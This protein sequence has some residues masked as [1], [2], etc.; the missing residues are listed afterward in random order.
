MPADCP[1]PSRR[2][3]EVAQIQT[4]AAKGKTTS[5]DGVELPYL[6]VANVQDGYVDLREIK[7]I[8]VEPQQV[9]RYSL[10]SGDVL[11]TEGGDAD[12]LGR[13]C[14]WQGQI[15]PCLHQNH[16]FAVRTDRTCLL[17]EFLSLY[18]A[19]ASG[20]S[21]FLE[22]AKQTTNL[23]SVNS[24]QL[25]DFPVAIPPL[26]EQRKIT[27]ILSSVDDAI[28]TTQAVIDQLG[29]VK[30]ALM[31]ELL[32]RGIPGRHTKFKQTEIG[33]VPAEW[34]VRTLGSLCSEPG[35]YGANVPKRAYDSLLPR[36]VRITDIT[37]DSELA[38]DNKASISEQDAAPFALRIGDIVFARSG[39]TVGKTYVYSPQ[40][41][42]CSHAGYLIRFHP[43]SSRML[44]SFLGQ[45]TH[46]ERYL[47]WVQESQR[48]QAQPNINAT[49]YSSL[50]LPVP[51]LAE[52]EHIVGALAKV[53]ERRKAESLVLIELAKLKAALTSA[54]LTGDLRVTP[55]E[56]PA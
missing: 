48:A 8:W 17:P 55:D 45:V 13:G 2:L 33:E 42:R 43:D 51:S 12:K 56:H 11:F 50:L 24:S 36:Y 23:A 41:G 44:V 7:T 14:V 37:A 3:A 31:A 32:T 15:E 6:R 5:A 49:E 29:V 20:R 38:S 35:R 53:D 27:A 39:A 28:Q 47:R 46:S 10:R 21:Y 18:A 16:I 1:W 26:G 34:E 22:C 54:L 9:E 40:D 30:K 19:S 25:K 4:G 52:Q